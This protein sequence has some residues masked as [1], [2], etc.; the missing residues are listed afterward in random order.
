MGG[1]GDTSTTVFRP[2]TIGLAASYLYEFLKDNPAAGNN[3]PAPTS[4][5]DFNNRLS[6][7]WSQWNL[8]NFNLTRAITRAELA[9]MI[10]HLV[11]PF[12]KA[13]D[14]KGYYGKK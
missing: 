4:E 12:A 10:D 14:H 1:S 7:A 5:A 8:S 6:T 2:L 13:V 11:N 3:Q 9:V